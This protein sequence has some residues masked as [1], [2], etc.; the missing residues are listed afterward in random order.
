M[1]ITSTPTV[2][3]EAQ[4]ES[5]RTPQSRVIPAY[6]VPPPPP[7][8]FL[9]PARPP[10]APPPPAVPS[11]RVVNG[12][13]TTALH[14]SH[15]ADKWLLV[16]LDFKSSLPYRLLCQSEDLS[17][18]VNAW[19]P[20]KSSSFAE[21]Y[22]SFFPASAELHIALI[23]PRS[24]ERLH[25]WGEPTNED[26]NDAE[27][28]EWDDVLEYLKTFISQHTLDDHDLGPLHH[29]DKPW[30]VR[31]K[32]DTPVLAPLPPT[33]VMDDEESAI[34]AAIAASLNESKRVLSEDE[35][36]FDDDDDDEDMD[37][38]D[39]N[40]SE[41]LEDD[42]DD[43]EM[44]DDEDSS[45]GLSNVNL[46][47][48]DSIS[49]ENTAITM[50]ETDSEGSSTDRVE[51]VPSRTL[52]SAMPIPGTSQVDLASP[53]TPVSFPGPVQR[54]GGDTTGRNMLDRTR[55]TGTSRRSS[56]PP[57]VPVPMPGRS[58]AISRSLNTTGG[59]TGM[60]S[61]VES[62]ASSVMERAHSRFKSANDPTLSDWRKEREMQDAELAASLEADRTKERARMEKEMAEKKTSDA[63]KAALDNLPREPEV[64]AADSCTIAL[65]LPGGERISRRFPKSTGTLADV[66]ALV[67]GSC[68][69]RI[70]DNGP[71]KVLRNRSGVLKK[72]A[73][74]DDILEDVMSEN[75]VMFIVHQ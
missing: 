12:N 71:E 36:E 63:R 34:A 61:S 66:A 24:G 51:V 14:S 57:S 49:P 19:R 64:G 67:F 72:G 54:P 29:R 65:R 15:Q 39:M 10:L 2:G 8:A 42:V 74:W 32:R 62:V 11:F 55:G 40:E 37:D 68:G 28:V 18:A 9:S 52:P 48:N 1:D 23:D 46:M 35:F 59:G 38:E 50:V 60:P 44:G 4:P 30:S 69:T 7:L 53:G 22:T 47:R 17:N 73:K 5:P 13:L 56:L 16:I 27:E 41:Q 45:E 6:T 58:P 31:T 25:V 70:D 21:S 20:R 3:D 43:Q 75:R 26:A 33:S